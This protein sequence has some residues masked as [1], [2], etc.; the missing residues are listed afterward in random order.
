MPP[1]AIPSPCHVDQSRSRA[2]VINDL[3]HLLPR[4]ESVSA[5]AR[6]LTFGL[7]ALDSYLPQSGL[8]CGA[9]HEVAPK[10]EADMPSAFGFITAVLSRIPQEGPLLF[11]LAKRKLSRFG[12]PSGHGFNSLG[13]DP[14]R[15]ILVEAGDEKQA[16]WAMEEALRS[17]VPA[18]VAGMA[19]E[20]F[21]LKTSQRLHFAAAAA[22]IPLVLL[23]TVG[24]LDASATVTRWRVGSAPAA[25]DRFG[26]MVRSR[27]RLELERCRNG[28]SGEW[29]VEFDHAAHC[30][31]L[32][33]ALAG[34][35]HAGGAGAQ[36]FAQSRKRTHRS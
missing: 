16:F 10:T 27:W 22:D 15:V 24:D 35:A 26:Q 18:V 36:S 29:L 14:A 19:G 28:R 23:R 12:L 4:M 33:S 13:L 32:D 5:K 20:K 21:D 17:G 11:V 31:S 2:E 34:S 6:V 30:F 1:L 8:I 7:P 3:R 9:L 25:R